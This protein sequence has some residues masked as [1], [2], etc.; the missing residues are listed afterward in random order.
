MSAPAILSHLR[1]LSSAERGDRELL[2]AFAMR[3]DDAAFAA[4]VRRHGPLVL[5]VCLRVLRQEQDAEDAFQ[6]TFLVLARKAEAL[7]TE[8]VGGW[9]HGVA[10]NVAQRLRRSAARR[11]CHETRVGAP[12]SGGPVAEASLRELQ[13]LLD[14]EV[15]RLPEKLRAPF[16]ACCLEGQS[17]SEVAH[18]LGWKEGTVSS[19]LA[20]A[21]ERLRAR[22]LRRG[23]TLSAALT[24][25]AL[26]ARATAAPTTLV[27]ATR[28]TALA[29][30]SGTAPI[31]PSIASLAEGALGAGAWRLK[32]AMF[33]LLAAGAAVGYRLSVH[34]E[35]PDQVPEQKQEEKPTAEH[36]KPIA[37]QYGDPLPANAVARLG[38]LRLR[39]GGPV[40][41]VAF[42]PDGKTLVSGSNDKTA[43]L[44][45][46]AT[47]K[48]LQRFDDKLT[49]VKSV[50]FG[51]DGKTVFT[52]RFGGLR[53]WSV[54][55]GKDDPF[56][57]D[58]YHEGFCLA[59]SADGKILAAGR[60]KVVELYDTVAEQALRKI[61]GAPEN[62]EGLALSRDGKF[63][64]AAGRDNLIKLWDAT[65]GNLLH[66]LTGH[67]GQVT[68][69]AFSP[70]GKT[71]ASGSYD[72]TVRLWDVA[73]GKELPQCKGHEHWVEAVSFSPDGTLLA[74][75][76]RDWFIRFW[77][78]KSAKELR[79]IKGHLAPITGVAFSPDG[80]TLASGGLDNLI[81]LWDVKS[82][83]ERL[84]AMGMMGRIGSVA[85]LPD[86]K[87]VVSGSDEG[88]RV[89]DASSGKEIRRLTGKEPRYSYYVAVSPDGRLAA[90]GNFQDH[91]V[92]IW[93]IATGKEVGKLNF[94]EGAFIA[95]LAFSPDSKALASTCYE[96]I[97]QLW[98]VATGKELRRMAKEQKAASAVAFAPDGKTLATASGD[99]SGD[100]TLRFWETA[101]G[102]ELRQ[103][104]LH[105]WSAF[106]ITFSRDGKILAA[107]GGI[108]GVPNESSDVRLWDVATGRELPPLRGLKERGMAAVFS[109]DGRTL[110]TSGGDNTIRLWELATGKERGRLVGHA[111][112]VLS[113]SFA[114]SG[115]LLVSGSADTTG[116][117]WNVTGEQR[118]GNPAG[119]VT[120]TE[121]EARW[122]DLASEDAAKAWQAVWDLALSPKIAVPYLRERLLAAPA[123]SANKIAGWIKDLD[124]D[125]F[126]TRRAAASQLE[127]TGEQAEPALRKALE[128]T[129]SPELRR[130]ATRLLDKL[131]GLSS[132]QLRQL[133]AVETLEYM[134]TPEAR[135]VLQSLTKGAAEARLTREAQAALKRLAQRR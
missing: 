101:T 119:R 82:G 2:Q 69:V 46:V 106:D 116:L 58:K 111:S 11:R 44:W 33:M 104:D 45:D 121:L 30:C 25:L 74:S 55:T 14:A 98:D 48:E 88:I 27:E 132:E 109:P 8:A 16:V 47:G 96:G 130:Q 71:L 135:K 92:R 133:R 97:I 94:A 115:R 63:A 84:V 1:R 28:A 54:V 26:E 40:W 68:S 21:R 20:Q 87:T 70:D 86:G 80:K 122:S 125:D 78:P 53:R 57:K 95:G 79:K 38:T 93:E 127:S 103:M 113:V 124:A 17:K 22:L 107:V 120:P 73:T 5:G 117:V 19:R 6:A 102:K 32:I 72:K 64:A 75:A 100:H 56:D 36:R 39:H 49:W 60:G 129:P 108:P 10:W 35:Q 50:A 89:W 134:D 128:G 37:D 42:A 126:A 65:S 81:R 85:F 77:D 110:A 12:S 15:A 76:G 61:E 83:N 4:L 29:F 43:R 90:S 91:K 41:C 23:V 62:I 112:S 131:I 105:P 13:A 123:V 52:G 51:P 9:L 67:E 18:A 3:R 114:P 24:V 118:P 7:R 34:S 99:A 31:A 66:T 59:A